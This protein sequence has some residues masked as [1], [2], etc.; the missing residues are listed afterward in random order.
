MRRQT[1]NRCAH[2]HNRNGF[3]GFTLIE[4]LVV[5]AIIALLISILLP[6]LSRAK[7]QSRIVVC[8][9]NLRQIGLAMNGYFMDNNDWFPF[10]R[11][12]NFNYLHGF[13]YGGHPGRSPWWG[14]TD[15]AYRNTPRGRPFNPYI[16]PDL[17]NWDPPPTDP[18][19]EVVR[20]MPVYQCPSDTGGFWN[21]SNAEDPFSVKPLH[22][23]TGTSYDLNYHFAYNWAILKFSDG[24]RPRWQHRANAFLR[25]QRK[26]DQTTFIMLYEDPFD[27][28]MWLRFPRRGWHRQWNKHTFLFLDGHAG[29]VLTDTAKDSRGLGWKSCSGNSPSDPKAW[30]NRFYDPD[31]QYRLIS[32][33]PGW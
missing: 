33:L 28:A 2:T 9:S 5:V 26:R 4:L 23:E 18:Q 20:K 16:Y 11:H 30:W 14:Y 8:L 6:N 15:P 25:M 31:Y 22:Y 21:N 27:S 29:H 17:P 10:E 19:F 32:P 24:S 7:E 1:Y 12:N 3:V 13:Y